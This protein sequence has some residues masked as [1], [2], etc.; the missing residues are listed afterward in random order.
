MT[1]NIIL[2]FQRKVNVKQNVSNLMKIT[3]VKYMPYGGII[4]SL[5]GAMNF[6]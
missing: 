5:K 1:K 2:T 4:I 6:E 3:N